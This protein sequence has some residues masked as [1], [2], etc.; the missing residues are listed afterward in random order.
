MP[1]RSGSPEDARHVSALATADCCDRPRHSP[2]NGAHSGGQ[3]TVIPRL[4]RG[5]QGRGAWR[6]LSLSCSVVP[7]RGMPNSSESGALDRLSSYSAMDSRGSG[8]WAC[9]SGA[10][11][12]MKR[13]TSAPA[14][15]PLDSP[16]EAGNDV[17]LSATVSPVFQENDGWE[18]ARHSDAHSSLDEMTRTRGYPFWH[19]FGRMLAERKI[20]R[21]EMSNTWGYAS[22]L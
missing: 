8:N 5:I 4:R 18:A 21:Q 3:P 12:T 20:S 6:A 15:R 17:C 13:A 1:A 22:R 16:P 7:Q 9:P 2:E 10:P 11:L 19:R 14:A